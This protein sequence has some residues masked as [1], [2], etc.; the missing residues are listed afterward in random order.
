[1]LPPFSAVVV[2]SDLG[3]IT[4]QLSQGLNGAA[5]TIVPIAGQHS[6]SESVAAAV[7]GVAMSHGIA[8]PAQLPF[9]RQESA[10]PGRFL[11]RSVL[12]VAKQRSS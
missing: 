3:R 8:I 6:M 4:D 5:L 10:H 11:P 7:A 1:M 9:Q 12:G 2:E